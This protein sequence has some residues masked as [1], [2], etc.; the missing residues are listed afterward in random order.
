MY[1]I[2]KPAVESRTPTTKEIGS[3]KNF[4]RSETPSPNR[5]TPIN[6]MKALFISPNLKAQ[7]RAASPTLSGV[8]GLFDLP[9][10]DFYRLM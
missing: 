3:A 5:P 8:V 7:E 9:F 10:D 4:S 1:A 2:T 6:V